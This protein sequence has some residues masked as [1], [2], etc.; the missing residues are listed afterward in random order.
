MKAH[1]DP[2]S[3]QP[4]VGGPAGR[5]WRMEMSAQYVRAGIPPGEMADVAAWI[6]EAPHAHPFWHSYVIM[7]QHLRPIARGKPAVL[8]LPEATHEM[9]VW[10]LSPD[11]PREPM[12]HGGRLSLMEPRNFAAQMVCASDEHAI[13]RVYETAIVPIVSG[14]LSPDTD[15]TRD[16]VARFGDNM[17]LDRPDRSGT[18]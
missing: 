7:L 2:I 14:Q 8:Y 4:D 5:A 11:R 12:L 3:I 13:I 9:N 18:H 16:W 15:F 17:M 1:E 6:V 10:A